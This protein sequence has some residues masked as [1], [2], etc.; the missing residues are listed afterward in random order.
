GRTKVNVRPS[1]SDA[2]AAIQT[3]GGTVRTA[4]VARVMSARSYR[5]VVAVFIAGV[6][7][8]YA[9]RLRDS[10]IYLSHDEVMFA[11]NAHEI[12]LT[13]RDLGGN[14][15]PLYVHVTGSYWLTAA[16]MYVGAL[17]QRLMPL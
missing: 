6:A 16:V 4:P 11:L 12:A 3:A 10:P 7:A 5:V 8:I 13:G 9:W 15:L 1:S 17:V 14:L 2:A